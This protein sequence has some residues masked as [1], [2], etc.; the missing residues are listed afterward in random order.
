MLKRR[1]CILIHVPTFV[2]LLLDINCKGIVIGVKY[3]VS[4]LLLG[5]T[6]HHG[7]LRLSNMQSNTLRAK[8]VQKATTSIEVL[9]WVPKN[10]GRGNIM[11]IRP[12]FNTFKKDCP[13]WNPIFPWL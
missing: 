13:F 6:D 9:G 5:F 1:D 8:L 4:A 2:K 10:T 3:F 11:M 7:S 12:L